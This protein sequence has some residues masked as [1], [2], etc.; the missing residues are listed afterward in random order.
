MPISQGI[1]IIN[2]ADLMY[3]HRELLAHPLCWTSRHAEIIG[4]R[5]Q[6]IQ[7]LRLWK[8]LE[9]NNGPIS[10]RR[11]RLLGAP[12]QVRRHRKPPGE[13]HCPRWAFMMNVG[14]I[15]LKSHKPWWKVTQNR[16][17][18][19]TKAIALLDRAVTVGEPLQRSTTHHTGKSLDKRIGSKAAN[20]ESI[21][22]RIVRE[23]FTGGI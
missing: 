10:W 3:Y 23:V 11:N 20:V 18:I 16:R 15:Q 12:G 14:E 6:P 22:I 8:I 4:F 21:L 2:S 13:F 1:N 9:V 17:N 19:K 7:M 5:F